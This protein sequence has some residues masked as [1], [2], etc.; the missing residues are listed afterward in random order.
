M[1]DRIR[2]HGSGFAAQGRGFYVWD[3]DRRAVRDFLAALAPFER[4]LHSTPSPVAPIRGLGEEPSC[5]PSDARKPTR[6]T[7]KAS[8]PSTSLTTR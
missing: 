5:S 8:T 3:R 7:A 6:V 4:D 2:K 1:S